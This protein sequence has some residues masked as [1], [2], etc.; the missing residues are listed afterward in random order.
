MTSTTDLVDH[1]RLDAECHDNF[2]LIYSPVPGRRNAKREDKWSKTNAL[3]QGSFGI[4]WLEENL[5][6]G[7][8]NLR[9]VKV[10]IKGLGYGTGF[11]IDYARELYAMARLTR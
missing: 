6:E 10:I 2:T 8:Q 9:A 7:T 11:K 3:G 4:V 5:C 1:F